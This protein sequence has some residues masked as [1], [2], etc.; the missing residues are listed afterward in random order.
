MPKRLYNKYG[1]GVTEHARKIGKI[2]DNAMEEVSK[3]TRKHDLD[4]RDLSSWCIIA[5]INATS[6]L[7][8]ERAIRM[9]RLEDKKKGK[10]KK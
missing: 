1:A 8:L 4:T 7:T 6:H 3:Y 2:M 5:V 9:K 10:H